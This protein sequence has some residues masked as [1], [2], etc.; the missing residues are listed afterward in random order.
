MTFSCNKL[1]ISIMYLNFGSLAS[2]CA[3]T[4]ELC[5]AGSGAKAFAM[6]IGRLLG[7]DILRGEETLCEIPMYE[8]WPR[9]LPVL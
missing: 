3:C 4:S 5:K 7:V 1:C 9:A 8:L 6:A 2:R